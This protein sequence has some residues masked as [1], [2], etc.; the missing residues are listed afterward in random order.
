MAF[1]A[2]NTAV[3]NGSGRST[4]V[5]AEGA[6]LVQAS[7]GNVGAQIR[8]TPASAEARATTS[9]LAYVERPTDAALAVGAAGAAL[10]GVSLDTSPVPAAATAALSASYF[11]QRPA[12]ASTSAEG[13]ADAV[14]DRDARAAAAAT[15]SCFASTA[16]V[17]TERRAVS[18]TTATGTA[19]DDGTAYRRRVLR[20]PAATAEAQG[21]GD[22]AFVF[23]SYPRGASAR[24]QSNRPRP[25]KQAYASGSVHSTA[26]ASGWA[27]PNR[28]AEGDAYALTAASGY[29]HSSGAPALGSATATAEGSFHRRVR[30]A[31]SPA[32]AGASATAPSDVFTAKLVEAHALARADVVGEEVLYSVGSGFWFLRGAASVRAEPATDTLSVANYAAGRSDSSAGAVGNPSKVFVRSGAAHAPASAEADSSVASLLFASV[33]ARSSGTAA[34]KRYRGALSATRARAKGYPS[35]LREAVARG[36]AVAHA[37]PAVASARVRFG[38]S[39]P[40]AGVAS[41]EAT[42]VRDAY[43]AGTGSGAASIAGGVA[44][45]AYETAPD[46]RTLIISAG[47]RDVVVSYENRE[48]VL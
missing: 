48:V 22:A 27:D 44:V 4:A 40:V 19:S 9:A 11:A 26:T 36:G 16:T 35:S 18:D 25:P 21:D 34:P 45:N 1:T 8:V 12:T 38:G 10:S 15:A 41:Y 30:A 33:S 24:A 39:L 46:W 31:A 43:A 32:T 23:L 20:P 13:A 17:S 3:L 2:L 14:A 5:P 6:A 42:A 29:V 28:Y 7:A 37:L 47:R